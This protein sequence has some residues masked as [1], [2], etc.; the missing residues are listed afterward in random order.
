MAIDET[1]KQTKDLVKNLIAPKLAVFEQNDKRDLSSVTKPKQP[2]PW[3]VSST[4]FNIL[5]DSQQADLKKVN[6]QLEKIQKMLATT[7]T[8]LN[9]TLGRLVTILKAIEDPL[10]LLFQLL[11]SEILKLE[12]TLGSNMGIFML[13]D[14]SERIKVKLTLG[15][16][17]I[18]DAGSGLNIAGGFNNQ[19]G[20]ALG[21]LP[22]SVSNNPLALTHLPS[23]QEAREIEKVSVRL[24][25]FLRIFDEY[26]NDIIGIIEN[27][28]TVYD[29]ANKALA[30][31]T[32]NAATGLQAGNIRSHYFVGDK[33][34]TNAPPTQT[35]QANSTLRTYFELPVLSDV[36][37][38]VSS[39]GATNYDRETYIGLIVH[40]HIL[41]KMY[42]VN[43][44]TV[45]INTVE[46]GVSGFGFILHPNPGATS[47]PTSTPD[48]NQINYADSVLW[49]KA[50]LKKV[51]AQA[52]KVGTSREAPLQKSTFTENQTR[53]AANEEEKA[54]FALVGSAVYQFIAIMADSSTT[55]L[56]KRI[57]T[58]KIIEAY[59]RKKLPGVD[60]ST[61][62]TKTFINS[63]IV[64]KP[65]AK[66]AGV[67]S[68]Y[69]ATL[70]QNLIT[71]NSGTNIDQLSGID[72]ETKLNYKNYF[73]MQPNVAKDYFGN[74]KLYRIETKYGLDADVAKLEELAGVLRETVGGAVESKERLILSNLFLRMQNLIRTANL[75]DVHTPQ[76]RVS[77]NGRT[78]NRNIIETSNTRS[79]KNDFSVSIP[80][81]VRNQIKLIEESIA[82]Q[83]DSVN[84]VNDLSR[85]KKEYYN[86]TLDSFLLSLDNKFIK[87]Q[88]VFD[89]L[90]LRGTDLATATKP[91]I[92]NAQLL[93]TADP[94]GVDEFI[95]LSSFVIEII[96]SIKATF[97]PFL[98]LKIAALD[99]KKDIAKAQDTD[100][101]Q[102]VETIKK[103]VQ[104]E[105]DWNDDIIGEYSTGIISKT[106]VGLTVK[107]SVESYFEQ[108]KQLLSG[109]LEETF[110]QSKFNVEEVLAAVFN[111][112]IQGNLLLS[113][114]GA[115]FDINKLNNGEAKTYPDNLGN[116]FNLY[117]ESFDTNEAPDVRKQRL[118]KEAPHLTRLVDD[119]SDASSPGESLG[120]IKITKFQKKLLEKQVFCRYYRGLNIERLM[121]DHG[122]IE[123]KNFLKAAKIPQKIR[124][125]KQLINDNIESNMADGLGAVER[126]SN[127]LASI[128]DYLCANDDSQTVTLPK[129]IQSSLSKKQ[130]E[131]TDQLNIATSTK[132]DKEKELNNKIKKINFT[133]NSVSGASD[134][135]SAKKLIEET[136]SLINEVGGYKYYYDERSKT[137]KIGTEA[138][139]G[140]VT[141]QVNNLQL[142]LDSYAGQVSNA[143]LDLASSAK[144][145]S[146]ISKMDTQISLTKQ[147]IA[148]FEA[149][150]TLN[151]NDDADRLKRELTSLEDLRKKTVQGGVSGASEVSFI[152][153]S[154]EKLGELNNAQR[155]F[156]RI[157]DD[158][159]DVNSIL[160]AE[161]TIFG[162][163]LLIDT[164]EVGQQISTS[165][166][167]EITI[168][169]FNAFMKFLLDGDIINFANV[170][171][172]NNPAITQMTKDKLSF[173]I[174]GGKINTGAFTT[175]LTTPQFVNTKLK[176][177]NKN[178][179]PVGYSY[180][181]LQQ[182]YKEYGT[183][184][185]NKIHT[186][187]LFFSIED[188]SGSSF[189]STYL[190]YIDFTLRSLINTSTNAQNTN[191]VAKNNN[192]LSLLNTL[193][194]KFQ[195]YCD[196]LIDGSSITTGKFAVVNTTN[197]AI[198]SIFSKIDI[199]TKL[200][201]SSY[202]P[203]LEISKAEVLDS[204][205]FIDTE[206]SF[207][208]K[209]GQ[210]GSGSDPASLGADYNSYQVTGY[211]EVKKQLDNTN[212][213]FL[214][215]LNLREK[216]LAD[217]KEK[218]D[219]DLK[220]L[221]QGVTP[222]DTTDNRGFFQLMLR[223]KNEWVE[224]IITAFTN[225]DDKRKPSFPDDMSSRNPLKVTS[226]VSNTSS[227]STQSVQIVTDREIDDIKKILGDVTGGLTDALAKVNANSDMA[228]LIYLM[229]ASDIVAFFN[230]VRPVYDTFIS[231]RDGKPSPIK[232]KFDEYTTKIEKTFMEVADSVSEL[233]NDVKADAEFVS[234]AFKDKGFLESMKTIAKGFISFD[235]SE[236]E[237][238]SRALKAST[239]LPPEVANGITDKWASI[240]LTD[241]PPFQQLSRISMGLAGLLKGLARPKIALAKTIE[242]ILNNLN[243]KINLLK[244]IV[245]GINLMIEFLSFLGSFQ[246]DAATLEL[247]NV[248]SVSFVE[249]CLRNSD[250]FPKPYGIST[251]DEKFFIASVVFVMP[252][253]IYAI[254][255]KFVK[256]S[257]RTAPVQFT[258]ATPPT[259]AT[260]NSLLTT[261]GGTGT[262][263]TTGNN[264][265]VTIVV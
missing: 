84:S 104:N 172:P 243:R 152:T 190:D 146:S 17:T 217:A 16:T 47:A 15:N 170:I 175:D 50:Y 125:L 9:N 262:T 233:V 209:A 37:S 121:S 225:E 220:S 219:K 107:Q 234:E 212:P 30:K 261:P 229:T 187:K 174:S 11:A 113:D 100:G 238:I 155:E 201:Y 130:K 103:L 8:I 75:S 70:I 76:L 126:L 99:I 42:V 150:P 36:L 73:L 24:G 139:T 265:G 43:D 226:P 55:P 171:L 204:E 223:S 59:F 147:R 13:D 186:K 86:K 77:D 143:Q 158:F 160:T 154:L 205:L 264:G 118:L 136:N 5:S 51:A 117:Q 199:T 48:A 230:K 106:F 29:N 60:T 82:T 74:E 111:E 169:E 188:T 241:I 249:Q 71:P 96:N 69:D 20:K 218:F 101:T 67:T 18:I 140:T 149:R 39:D 231:M 91:V 161:N 194:S 246:I 210:R 247:E 179:L 120:N 168:N 239:K 255:K 254:F 228:V 181:I 124:D 115:F 184:Y 208:I 216:Q 183:I 215:P 242:R 240:R 156:Q 66:N 105:I 258:P 221:S 260:S 62:T 182:Q 3:K 68:A 162:L 21:L 129:E 144:L 102:T 78:T 108:L 92:A 4:K 227:P 252:M 57:K 52:D 163:P 89:R 87:L 38:Q 98:A 83:I 159:N 33:Q 28:K 177:I 112:K 250:N 128:N 153:K 198:V 166:L 214:L 14:V 58:Y 133:N 189:V 193:K 72:N 44:T 151:K 1:Q 185:D 116:I 81:N 164:Y 10:A 145:E 203:Y 253:P 131:I 135:V 137:I 22:S 114:S 61:P 237:R 197:K 90:K 195:D 95:I 235:C 45:D 191:E 196:I 80:G 46:P 202:K 53:L 94:V 79:E 206:S 65:E 213:S 256:V 200:D 192:I 40:K 176:T 2:P 148:E 141:K 110:F 142:K 7:Q 41:P 93:D 123:P 119:G 12:A 244:K 97:Q 173:V 132:K 85:Y 88:E 31:L 122:I 251:D 257:D 222:E 19:Y 224:E 236:T 35:N 26:N 32:V 180:A 27:A 232:L 157:A 6:Q 127:W 25:E 34:N 56:Q 54:L 165:Q 63:A 248:R 134:V 64:V 263:D 207:R 259:L 23:A 109:N 178:D 245:Q 167:K 138:I 211:K 49:D